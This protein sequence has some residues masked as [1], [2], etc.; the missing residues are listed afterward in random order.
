[1]INPLAIETAQEVLREHKRSEIATPDDVVDVFCSR[2][3]LWDE[4]WP[5]AAVVLAQAVLAPTDVIR[6][7]VATGANVAAGGGPVG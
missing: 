7:V 2:C 5:C 4:P 3:Y 6:T 1:M